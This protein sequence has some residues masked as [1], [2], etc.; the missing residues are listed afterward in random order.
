MPIL[1]D[2]R[3]TKEISLPN[4]PDSKVAIYNSVLVKDSDDLASIGK[5]PKPSVMLKV[6]P[7]LIACWNFTD[8]NNQ[9][10][11]VSENTLSLLDTES[12]VFILNS[13]MEFSAELKKK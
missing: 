10:L 3:M 5:D 11:E 2:F 8:E 6:L 4:Y 13:V 9:D 7:K 1:K 12:I